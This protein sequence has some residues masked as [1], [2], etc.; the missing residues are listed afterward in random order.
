[1]L[2]AVDAA[3]AAAGRDPR[4]LPRSAEALVRTIE[5]A[6][7]GAARGAGAARDAGRARRRPAAIRGARHRPRPGPAPAEPARRG[8]GVRARHRGAG[9]RL[10]SAFRLLG[11]RWRAPAGGHGSRLSGGHRRRLGAPRPHYRRCVRVPERDV[12]RV[13]ELRRR[14]R[15]R[16]WPASRDVTVRPHEHGTPR[17]EARGGRERPVVDDSASSPMINDPER[18]GTTPWASPG[19]GRRSRG[20]AARGP[21]PAVRRAATPCACPHRHAGLKPSPAQVLTVDA[22]PAAVSSQAC[23]TRPPGWRRRS[24]VRT[25]RTPARSPQTGRRTRRPRATRPVLPWCRREE[26]GRRRG[27]APR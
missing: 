21:R 20:Q 11:R 17:A 10:S 12:H 9:R 27:R 13:A 24:R 15:G 16:R 5:A 23:G 26:P 18:D 2:A 19:R 6:G 7:R 14:V 25:P 8:R 3:C 1:M 4:T 22:R